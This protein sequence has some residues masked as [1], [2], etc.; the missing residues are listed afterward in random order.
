M[1]VSVILR[2]SLSVTVENY[3]IR[4]NELLIYRHVLVNQQVTLVPCSFRQ[5]PILW[6]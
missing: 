2:L 4:L 5:R 1:A 3:W 6:T